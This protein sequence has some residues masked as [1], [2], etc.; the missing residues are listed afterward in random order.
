MLAAYLR[1][2]HIQPR[3]S[4]SDGQASVTILSDESPGLLERLRRALERVGIECAIQPAGAAVR[5]GVAYIRSIDPKLGG[6]S[7]FVQ[8]ATLGAK[9]AL[10]VNTPGSVRIAEWSPLAT[11]ALRDRGVPQPRRMWCLDH[12]DLQ[13]AFEV[14]GAPVVFEGVVTRRRAMASSRDE[15]ERAFDDAVGAHAPRGA[16]AEAP[17]RAQVANLSVMV[18]DG[19]CIPLNTRRMRTVSPL[20]GM[21]AALV[22]G[23]AVAALGASAMAVD[24]TIDENDDAY[25]TRVD[26]APH[27][28]RL[29]DEA[30][31]ALVGGIADRLAM[32]WPPVRRR[33]RNAA[34]SSAAFS[35]VGHPC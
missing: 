16:M 7:L 13:R 4:T 8:V 28:G 35:Q 29:N 3:T 25:V 2:M 23:D 30:I 10:M 17:L 12:D 33:P 18:I 22:A 11:H 9:P 26:P 1:C 5:I 14:L 20:A 19:A 31:S 32:A 6:G 15:L 34:R 24:V 21:R 27:L